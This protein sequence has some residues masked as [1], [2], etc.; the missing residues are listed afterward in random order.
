MQKLKFRKMRR[1]SPDPDSLGGSVPILRIKI[2]APIE[3]RIISVAANG[4]AL[5]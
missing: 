2:I 5:L 4:N 3:S 1:R